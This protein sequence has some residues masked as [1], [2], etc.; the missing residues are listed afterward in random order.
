MT[1][2]PEMRRPGRDN[3]RAAAEQV[4]A[5]Q[6]DSTLDEP[7][8]RDRIHAFDPV[9]HR[10]YLTQVARAHVD[11]EGCGCNGCTRRRSA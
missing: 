7:S 2:P 4:T 8:I 11:I 1:R 3:D 9:S 6:P 10:W 5:E